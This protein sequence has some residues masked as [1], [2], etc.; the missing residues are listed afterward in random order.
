MRTKHQQGALQSRT[1]RG[2]L[3]LHCPACLSYL[4]QNIHLY[5]TSLSQTGLVHRKCCTLTCLSPL[6]CTEMLDYLGVP[7]VTAAGE[8]EAMCAYLD[9]QGLVDGCIT[10]DGDAFLYGAQTVYRNFN[11]NSKV[12]VRVISQVRHKASSGWATLGIRSEFTPVIKTHYS[13]LT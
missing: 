12:S 5:V 10:N 8:A 1:Q 4:A 3:A 2:W 13:T 6:Q 9:W 11:V 7:W